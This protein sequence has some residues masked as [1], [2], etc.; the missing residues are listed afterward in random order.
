MIMN[1]HL[2]SANQQRQEDNVLP[3]RTKIIINSEG[4]PIQQHNEVEYPSFHKIRHF[5]YTNNIFKRLVISEVDISD[6]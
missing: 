3:G 1:V 5:L 6:I 2:I 4:Q